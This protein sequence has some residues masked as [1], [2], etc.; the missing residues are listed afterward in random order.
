[1]TSCSHSTTA[2]NAVHTVHK[3]LDLSTNILTLNNSSNLTQIPPTRTTSTA[4]T[5]RL[6]QIIPRMIPSPNIKH[7]IQL[8]QRPLL[9]LRQTK[10]SKREPKKVPSRIP[11]K[12]ALVRKRIN[13]RRPRKRKNEIKAPARGRRKRHPCI[14][15]GE[16]ERFSGVG[17]GH[18]AHA[19]RVSDHEEVDSCGYAAELG[20]LVWDPEGEAGEEEA[21]GHVWECG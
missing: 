3:D 14:A 4:Q 9:R 21:E 11:R 6:L 8:L 10:P 1:M 19:R 2:R 5:T 7:R 13:K 12:R 15:N 20:G 16:G 17:E 18:R